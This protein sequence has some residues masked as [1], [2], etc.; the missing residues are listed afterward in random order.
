MYM[1]NLLNVL[2]GVDQSFIFTEYNLFVSLF[3]GIHQIC[4]PAFPFDLSMQSGT[5]NYICNTFTPQIKGKCHCIN[6]ILHWLWNVN[7]ICT[8]LC[9]RIKS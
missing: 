2:A 5:Y 9:G 7:E 4:I 8:T 3:S 6:V 1:H